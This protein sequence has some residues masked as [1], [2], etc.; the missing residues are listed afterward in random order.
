[1]L[2]LL[3]KEYTRHEKLSD[4]FPKCKKEHLMNKRGENLF[5]VK[6]AKT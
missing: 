2:R 1:M 4:M 5:F 6:M 3:N